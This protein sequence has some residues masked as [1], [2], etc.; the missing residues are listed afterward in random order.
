[1]IK[2]QSLVREGHNIARERKCQSIV[3]IQCDECYI[4]RGGMKIP[5]KKLLIA[6]YLSNVKE[7]CPEKGTLYLIPER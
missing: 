3:V 7:G 5:R 4:I 6:W 2:M 1:M